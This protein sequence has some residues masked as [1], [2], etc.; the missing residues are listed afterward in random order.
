MR[1]VEI[2]RLQRA[3]LNELLAATRQIMLMR[4]VDSRSDLVRSTEWTYEKKQFILIA[5]DYFKWVNRGR[6]PFVRKVPVDALIPWMRKN[7]IRP[8]GGQT[9]TSLA[10]AIQQSIYMNGIKAKQYSFPIVEES[11][12][13][14]ADKIAMDLT[15]QIMDTLVLTI[16]D[17]N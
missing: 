10:Y 4:D 5:N 17:F 15:V 9:Y 2:K 13:L 12:E 11:M 7:N 14:I 16:E 6:M 3:L 8:S 1:E